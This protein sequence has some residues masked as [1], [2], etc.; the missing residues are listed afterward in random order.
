MGDIV[1]LFCTCF[2]AM[3]FKVLF[4]SDRDVSLGVVLLIAACALAMSIMVHGSGVITD[5]NDAKGDLLALLFTAK[6]Y[7]KSVLQ[8]AMRWMLA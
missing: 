7:T 2:M 3:S 1:L 5:D 4:W 8:H 6:T